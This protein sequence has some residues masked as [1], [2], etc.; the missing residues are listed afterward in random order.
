MSEQLCNCGEEGFNQLQQ[1][2]NQLQQSRTL[3]GQEI[4]DLLGP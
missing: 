2:S 3:Y 4:K 1:D